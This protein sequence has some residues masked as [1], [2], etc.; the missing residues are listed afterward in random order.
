M[1]EILT[2]L[3]LWIGANSTYNT[4]IPLPT[5]LFMDQKQMENVYYGPDYE[6]GKTGQLY[7]FYNLEKDVIV[8]PD[9]WDRHKPWHLSVLLHELVHY[10]QDTNGIQYQC[11]AEMEQESWPLQKQYLANVHNFHWEY[12]ALWHIVICTCGDGYR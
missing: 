3:L 1:N 2:A 7:G 10:V 6:V 5:V 4:D 8:L 11:S 12:D 9:S